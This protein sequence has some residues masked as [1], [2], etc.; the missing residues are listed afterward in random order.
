MQHYKGKIAVWDVV[1]EAVSIEGTSYRDC[2]FYKY[3]GKTYIDEAFKIAR[4]VD[5]TVKLYYN[6]YDDEGMNP[7]SD[8]VYELLKGL[9]ERGVPIDG[10]GMQMHYGKP[11]AAFTIAELKTNLKR[12]TDLGL[13]VVFSEMDVHRCTGMTETEQVTMYHDLVAACVN[14]PLCKAVTFWGITDKYSWLNSYS[15]LGCSGST[16]ALGDL[17]DDNF[18]KKPAYTGVLNAY[19]GL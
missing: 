13:E 11:N 6:D 18:K 15:P 8:F 3:L 4:E 7:K 19:L 5:P 1:N 14:E 17:W 12:L 16:K 9:K 2:P 10:V